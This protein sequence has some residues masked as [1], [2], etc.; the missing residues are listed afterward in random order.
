MR[1]QAQW[2][3]SAAALYFQRLNGIMCEFSQPASHRWTD[4][5]KHRDW[6]CVFIRSERAFTVL[7]QRSY[8][9]ATDTGRG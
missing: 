6:P 7:P 4:H 5:G 2:G 8:W 9:T 3:R 1:H